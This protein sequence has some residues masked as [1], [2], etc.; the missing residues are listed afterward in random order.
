MSSLVAGVRVDG[1]AGFATRIE[2]SRCPC[3]D[4]RGSKH[5]GDCDAVK[6]YRTVKVPWCRGLRARLLAARGIDVAPPAKPRPNGAMTDKVHRR[7]WSAADDAELLALDSEGLSDAEIGMR[8]GRTK[9]AVTH[10][11]SVLRRKAREEAV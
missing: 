9:A 10:Q 4:E 5:A 1:F 2:P 6:C 11:L 8:I 3:I 7:A